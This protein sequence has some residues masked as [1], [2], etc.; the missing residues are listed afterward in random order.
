MRRQMLLIPMVVAAL[1]AGCLFGGTAWGQD[2]EVEVAGLSAFGELASTPSRLTS[3]NAHDDARQGAYNCSQEREVIQAALKQTNAYLTLDPRSDYSDNS[4]FHIVRIASQGKDARKQIEAMKVLAGEFPTSD[5]ADDALMRLASLSPATMTVVELDRAA[6][7]ERL[8]HEYPLSPNVPSAMAL[9]AQTYKARE[10][11]DAAMRVSLDLAA[12]FPHTK[13]CAAALLEVGNAYRNDDLLEDALAAY[14]D[15]L[16]RFPFSDQADDALFQ[17]AETHRLARAN[18]PALDAY[19]AL[20]ANFPGSSNVPAARR[21][22]TNNFNMRFPPMGKCPCEIAAEMFS[23][24]GHIQ[25]M[26]RFAQ[27]IDLYRIILVEFRGS[28]IYDDALYQIGHCYEELDLLGMDISAAGGPEDRYTRRMEWREATGMDAIP[29]GEIRA[30]GDAVSAYMLLASQFVGSD[31]R[32]D[33]HHRVHELFKERKML[34]EEALACQDLLLR[35]PGSGHDCESLYTVINWYADEADFPECVKPYKVLSSAW[36]S[37]FPM[38]ITVSEDEFRAMMRYYLEASYLAH[39][40]VDKKKIPYQ[41]GPG[42]LM[43]DAAYYLGNIQVSYGKTKEGIKTLSQ[44]RARPES[45]QAAFAYFCIARASERVGDLETAAAAYQALIDG[46]PLSGLADDAQARL[47]ALLAG[48]EEPDVTAIATDV[49]ELI[50]KPVTTYDVYIGENVIVFCPFGYTAM[51]RAY[52]LPNIWDTAQASLANWTGVETALEDKQVIVMDT[53]TGAQAGE[54]IRL[55][56]TAL[57][58]PPQWDV[59][60]AQLASNFLEDPSIKLLQDLGEPVVTAFVRLAAADLQYELVSET[61]DTIGNA[62]AV[63]LPFENLVRQRDQATTAL[64]EYVRNG[65]DL[66][67]LNPDVATGMLLVLLDVTGYGTNGLVDWAP[68]KRFFQSVDECAPLVAQAASER[69]RH[70][71]FVHCLGEA[72]NSDLTQQFTDW[73]FDV[74]G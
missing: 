7:L 61:R 51:M 10:M 5:L 52:N 23:D 56:V 54:I 67:Q 20:L 30:T 69:D 55:P 57:D 47:D 35:F 71:L 15:I 9:L 14:E 40:E 21:A 31:L 17:I 45:D 49:E 18:G 29:S 37:I 19:Q 8:I 2:D 34:D 3:F 27:A 72:F 12:R 48:E 13:G 50:G 42:D 38:E 22:L 44:L 41:F 58:D 66:D 24:A 6:Q 63:K 39:Y 62:S 1:L 32:A 11:P 33:A 26:R 4:Y 28:D 43:D 53:A 65:A 25:A 74:R 68:Y 59:G 73:G 36:P 16:N 64:E 70:T 46:K 60:L